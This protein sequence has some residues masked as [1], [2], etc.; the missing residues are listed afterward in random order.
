MRGA[1]P[2]SARPVVEAYYAHRIMGYGL[3]AYDAAGSGA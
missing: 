2:A 1:L 3:A